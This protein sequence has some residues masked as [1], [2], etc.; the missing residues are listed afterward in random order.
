MMM[1]T[2]TETTNTKANHA[3]DII[4]NA[5]VTGEKLETVNPDK[6]ALWVGR[7][8]TRLVFTRSEK[9]DK[10]RG[11]WVMTECK[12]T[13]FECEKN[14][15]KIT[16]KKRFYAGDRI[17]FW[18]DDTKKRDNYEVWVPRFFYEKAVI[19][20]KHTVRD[21]KYK[22]SEGYVCIK[23][24]NAKSAVIIYREC[25]RVAGLLVHSEVE[26]EHETA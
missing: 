19:T 12:T 20:E 5:L 3:V 23:T 21:S 10:K 25:L 6:L 2:N 7:I 26:F 18:Y 15:E 11:L 8:T 17:E 22:D 16:V 14:G 9:H 13:D 24:D 1:T 4:N